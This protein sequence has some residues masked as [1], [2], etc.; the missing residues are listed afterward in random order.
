MT[1]LK[2]TILILTAP[3]GAGHTSAAK[4]IKDLVLA[5]YPEYRI[6]IRNFISISVPKMNKP[7]I[8]LYENNTRYTPLIYN[9]YYYFRKN[10]DTKYDLAHML[11]S[12]KITEYILKI[13]PDI[14]I[15]TFPVACEC[16]NDFKIKHPDNTTPVITVV[17]DVVNSK[18]WIHANTDYYFVPSRE[19]KN[20]FMN[21]GIDPERIKVTGVPVDNRFFM[22]RK[23]ASEYK[24]RIL[25][26]GGGRGLFDVDESFMKWLDSFVGDYSTDIKITIVTG[27]NKK[28]YHYLTEKNPLSNIEVL[29]FVE[30][31]PDLVENC[32][33]MITKPGGATLFEA[34]N[35]KTPV[36]VKYPKV[37]QE[38]ENAKF[39]IDNGL[40]LVYKTEKELVGIMNDLV[41]G[42]ID[43][44][45]DYMERN[46]TFVRHTI[47]QDLIP[48]YIND[49]LEDDWA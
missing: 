23:T 26:V 43:S 8:S 39:I 7:M 12:P 29:G 41:V 30:N 4:A 33:L 5:E 1:H 31:M 9:S 3:F 40:G 28:L 25:V 48:N 37:G 38:I 19:V 46:L 21:K 20:R 49:I 45:F 44:V 35:S 15:S 17:T 47:Y 32:D 24:Y 36:I 22:D 16:I 2:K 10:M 42:K 18:E 34:I 14:I 6:K 27:N 13:K 11:Y